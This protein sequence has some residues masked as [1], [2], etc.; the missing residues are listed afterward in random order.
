MGIDGGYKPPRINR[1]ESGHDLKRHFFTPVRFWAAN[2]AGVD[3]QST[4]LPIRLQAIS[5][6]LRKPSAAITAP[7]DFFLG[8]VDNRP[9]L[10]ILTVTAEKHFGECYSMCGEVPLMSLALVDHS[11]R[12]LTTDKPATPASE[13]ELSFDHLAALEAQKQRTKP[14]TQNLVNSE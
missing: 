14:Q 4:G 12:P 13:V 11:G 3:V 1:I 7:Q 9:H 10:P 6:A 5:K 2:R 8:R